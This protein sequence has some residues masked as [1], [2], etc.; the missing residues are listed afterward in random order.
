MKQITYETQVE[1]SYRI[2]KEKQTQKI[3]IR[4]CNRRKIKF[5]FIWNYTA[6]I[7]ST[8]DRYIKM[9]LSEQPKRSEEEEEKI[10]DG[11]KKNC[12]NKNKKTNA[13]IRKK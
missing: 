7:P 8:H 9:T 4:Q 11:N 10:V 5:F 2:T 1:Q 3:Y 6:H 12:D 13:K